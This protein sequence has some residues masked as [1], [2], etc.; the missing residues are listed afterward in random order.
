VLVLWTLNPAMLWHCV[1][2]A[3]VDVLGVALIVAALLVLHRAPLPRWGV[4]VLVGAL[5]GA[6]A[7]VKA[8]LILAGLGM[9]WTVRRS[10][11]DLLALGLGGALVLGTSYLVAGRTAV[12][13]LRSK[14]DSFSPIS[15]W[16]WPLHLIQDNLWKTGPMSAIGLVAGAL[17][18]ALLAWRLA[19]AHQDMP[20]VR[21]VFVLLCG[22][23]VTSP[24][25]RPWYD[26]IIFSLLA[27][28]PPTQIDGLLVIR[29][30][31]GTYG[32]LPGVLSPPPVSYPGPMQWIAK[33]F[34]PWIVS[35]AMSL[36]LLLITIRLI[37]RN[38]P[39][40]WD[41]FGIRQP[42]DH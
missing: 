27:L 33:V 15:P 30:G 5:L 40:R 39:L 8:P 32:F 7:A 12:H 11:R 29:G 17:L 1:S 28:L 13:V 4:L 16:R 26:A 10:L 37:P 42:N 25:Q 24:L 9:A 35:A 22:W 34:V 18:I 3:H 21:P 2:G 6:A 36:M 14:S 20:E 31:F 19:P 23:L 38:T 41:K